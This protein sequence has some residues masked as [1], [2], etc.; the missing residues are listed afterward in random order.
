MNRV[1]LGLQRK[2][3]VFNIL[4]VF[5]LS[6]MTVASNCRFWFRPFQA[7]PGLVTKVTPK[8]HAL[9]YST[10]IVDGVMFHHCEGGNAHLLRPGDYVTVFY[11]PDAPGIATY[12]SSRFS[13]ISSLVFI[14]IGAI[15][16]TAFIWTVGPAIAR[17]VQPCQK[18]SVLP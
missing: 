12:D 16:F 7:G 5:V 10:Y 4:I 2:L 17:R 1:A 15:F 6:A 3:I 9:V 8:D 18:V 13:V 11:V 14:C